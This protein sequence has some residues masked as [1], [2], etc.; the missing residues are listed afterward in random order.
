MK[1]ASYYNINSI[2]KAF[3]LLE[4]IVTK[5][6]FQLSELC[7]LLKYPKTTIHR[8]LLTLESLGYVQQ[9]SVSRG[10]VATIKIL[11]LGVKVVRNLNYIEIAKPLMVKLSEKTGETINLGILDGLDV[12]CVHNV[13]S[14]QYLRIAGQPIGHR[15]KAY[16]TGMGKV[17]LA[18]LSEEERAELFSNNSITPH[19]SKSLKT[20]SA[21][22]ENLQQVRN[23]GYAVDDEE[24]HKGVR[25]VGAPI[26]DNIPKVIAGISIVCPASRL[27]EEDIESLAKLITETAAVISN[28][29]GSLH[30]ERVNR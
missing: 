16:H 5:N 3:N 6:E 19:T 1:K 29:L 13:E 28:K 11:E 27:N 30:V 25:C 2:T 20:V 23:Q 10:Y 24:A 14:N 21:I 9:N 7:R 15:A 8:M 17:L 12:I 26:F 22:E 18:Y 4:I